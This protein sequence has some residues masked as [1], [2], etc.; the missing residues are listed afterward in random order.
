METVK[1]RELNGNCKVVSQIPQFLRHISEYQLLFVSLSLKGKEHVENNMF[2]NVLPS[3]LH[4]E[5]TIIV[6]EHL[7]KYLKTYYYQ[8]GAPEYI[9]NLIYCD[10][11]TRLY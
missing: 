4:W 2:I 5:N 8:N 1:F 6:R 9:Q 11:E 7:N 3:F 10:W